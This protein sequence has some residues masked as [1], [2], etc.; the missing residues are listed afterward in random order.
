MHA[1]SQDQATPALNAIIH[2]SSVLIK[3]IF[4]AKQALQQVELRQQFYHLTMKFLLFILAV[5]GAPV[6]GAG[7]TEGMNEILMDGCAP[8][9][10]AGIWTH[11]M[12]DVSSFLEAK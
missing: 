9:A 12:H 10:F 6:F 3:I 11:M 4:S 1:I 5:S 2:F 7:E 8:Q